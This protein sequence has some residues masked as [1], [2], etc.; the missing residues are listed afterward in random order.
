MDRR[1]APLAPRLALALLALTL[2]VLSPAGTP[3][4]AQNF[5]DGFNFLKAVR[6][7]DVL[8]AKTLMD[9]PGS[10]IINH[11]DYDSGETALIIAIKRRDTPWMGF[12]MQG[13][14]DV[15]LKDRDG[16]TPLM[17]AA[18]GSFPEGVR[19]LLAGKAL[20]N[21]SNSKGET[22]LIKAVHARDIDSVRVLL[23][24]GADPDRPD[25]L[26]GM[27][28]RDYAGRDPRAT[29][30]ARLLADAKPLTDSKKAGPQR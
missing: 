26:T 27:S 10:T 5:S 28:A 7:R 12:L 4:V 16:E 15:N 30:I 21:A 23:A 6:D 8:K 11:R 3:A 29:Q 18:Q 19:V 14:A 1:T 17:M 25:N 20:V 22:A 9:K 13:G 2:P 24:N